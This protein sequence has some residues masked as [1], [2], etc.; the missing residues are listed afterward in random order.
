VPTRAPTIAH[1]DAESGFSGGESQVF[2]LLE[3]LRSR[4]W[5]NLL[6]CPPGSASERA[7]RE[8][9]FAVRTRAMRNS[10]DLPAVLGLARDL[11]AARADLAHFHTARAHWLGGL[12]ARL[13]GVPAVATRRMDKRLRPGLRSRMTYT[14]LARR[15]AAIS[16]VVEEQLARGGVPRERLVRIE[17]AVDPAALRP[18]R[19]REAVR[20]ELGAAPDD[21]V[22]LALGALVERKG[23]DLAL[24]A[25]AE[26][27]RGG[28]AVRLWIAGE[29]P[30]R[31]ALQA[32]AQSLGIGERARLLGRRADVP[33]L[34][35]AADVVAMP[36]RAEGM[37]V[38]ALEAMAAGRPVVAARVGGLGEAV[39]HER[40]GLLVEPD[41]APALAAALARLVDDRALAARLGAA[42][43]ARIAERYHASRMC[44]A[45]DALYR[46]VLAE[47][48][49]APEVRRA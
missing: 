42:G 36:S 26:L 25:L 46:E 35:A 4:G 41:D 10:L 47:A 37:G 17:D 2:L 9:G 18:T 8:R 28:R 33:D 6:I 39:Q 16:G 15:T 13:A 14:A 19:A 7:A 38:A 21:C 44:D 48:G 32:L 23:H 22:L 43:P 24:R 11:R 40:T 20:A 29:G 12:A 34:L 1:L 31:A 27:A 45:Y 3:G 5:D 30:E 49:R